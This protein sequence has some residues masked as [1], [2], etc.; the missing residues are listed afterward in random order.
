MVVEVE[1]N[2]KKKKG[3]GEEE[4]MRE[5]LVDTP[6]L[7]NLLRGDGRG[8]GG[9]PGAEQEEEE[10]EIEKDRRQRREGLVDTVNGGGRDGHRRLY[11]LEGDGLGKSSFSFRFS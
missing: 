4:K 7:K 3:G 6:D 1:S 11:R 2:K 5:G 8:G 9:G 10:R